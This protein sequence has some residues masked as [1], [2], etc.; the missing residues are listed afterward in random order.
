MS[1]SFGL[2]R[3]VEIYCAV[4]GEKHRCLRKL[5]LRMVQYIDDRA[6]PYPSVGQA[7]FFESLIVQLVTALGGF[8]SFGDVTYEG[9]QIRFSKMQMWPLEEGQFLGYLINLKE[10]RLEIPEAKLKFFERFVAELL[11]QQSTTP[12]QKARFVGLVMSF[13]KAVTP[14][15]LYV[16]RMFARLTG[17]VKWDLAYET[18]EEER[19]VMTR[20][21]DNLRQWNG[22]RWARKPVKLVLCGDAS[23]EL[24][25]AY[26]V[27]AHEA[28]TVL[29][30][31][32][33]LDHHM[34]IPIDPH[35]FPLGSTVREAHIC[36]RS[37]QIALEQKAVALRGTLVIYIGDNL[38]M[39]QVL[40]QWYA[41]NPELCSELEQLYD[42]LLTHG[43]DVFAE[44]ERRSTENMKHADFLG[45]EG[46]VDNSQWALCDGEAGKVMDMYEAA[47]GGRPTI[48]GMAD[49]S[50]AKAAEF[51]SKELSPGC[52]GVDFFACLQ[53]LGGKSLAT[54]RQHLV[55]LNGDFAR[56]RD[57]LM[58]IHE[59]RLNVILVFPVWPGII[60]DLIKLM[61]VVAGPHYLPNKP[62]LFIAGPRVAKRDTERTRF[63][64]AS[65]LI[66]YGNASGG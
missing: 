56:M 43:V 24:G 48:D 8:L 16:R 53:M 57:I 13:I 6:S 30:G 21:K 38:G 29:R 58:A 42:L 51:V 28:K 60:E 55:W 23:V 63:R 34:V 11:T 10:K 25:A 35:V 39:T 44:W 31:A 12:R 54:G 27:K 49:P 14:A 32:P 47:A 17:E 65:V 59:T 50:N 36:R 45:K 62:K 4:E 40:N 46:A 15:R 1:M 20:F 66:M 41:K 22:Q 64:V 26:E 2:S 37:I 3:A 7:L 33:L 61:P 5:G 52:A 18:P 19:Y 9:G